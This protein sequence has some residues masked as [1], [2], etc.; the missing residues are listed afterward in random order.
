MR[1]RRG[2]NGEVTSE[3]K[4]KWGQGEC[5]RKKNEG[6]ECKESFKKLKE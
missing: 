6:E 1:I 3:K 2:K 4:M 5:G